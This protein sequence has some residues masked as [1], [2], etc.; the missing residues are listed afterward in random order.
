MRRIE[1]RKEKIKKI[2]MSIILAGIMVFSGFAIMVG[3]NQQ[4]LTYNDFKFTQGDDQKLYTEVSEGKMVGFR[5]FPSDLKNMSVP[6]EAVKLLKDS[7]VIVMTFNSS[8]D[9]MWVLSYLE[10]LEFEIAQELDDKVFVNA[11]TEKSDA[12]AAFPIMDCSNATLQQPVVYF[13]IVKNQ[14]SITVE[15]NCIMLKSDESG[16]YALK[17][18]LLYRYFGVIND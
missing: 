11:V 2:W 1:N 15:N 8:Y 12:Y 3:N 9:K 7:P 4:S 17:D 14:T 13:E 6:S 16:F 10:T 5:Y 18:L